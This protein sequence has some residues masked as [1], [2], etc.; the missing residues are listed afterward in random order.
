MSTAL[1]SPVGPPLSLRQGKG[2]FGTNRPFEG[3][4]RVNNEILT[5]ES[6][7]P[8]LDWITLFE[9]D[10]ATANKTD[11]QAAALEQCLGTLNEAGV[12]HAFT[13]RLAAALF[14]LLIISAILNAA[15][16]VA[17]FLCGSGFGLPVFIIGL[18]DE[19]LMVCCIGVFIGITNHEVGRYI[20]ASVNLGDI[21]GQAA[22]GVGFW[23]LVAIF[24]A[25]AISH[26][27]LFFVTLVVCL[28]IILIPILLLLCCCLGGDSRE[29]T[30]VY[31]RARV[32]DIYGTTRL[33]KEARW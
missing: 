7:R 33:D 31:V 5:C 16:L 13:S 14:A 19:V 2:R 29:G 11:E 26:P 15:A 24:A 20:P 21:D 9:A 27:L 30:V 12:D 3:S 4:C 10:I 17:A 32:D 1:A 6:H 25:R 18:V 22:L 28:L 8:K 23:M